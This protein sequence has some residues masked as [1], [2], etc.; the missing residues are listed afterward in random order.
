[1]EGGAGA[2]QGGASQQRTGGASMD[3][4]GALW[5]KSSGERVYMPVDSLGFSARAR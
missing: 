5:T 1:M 4:A 3:T 2:S